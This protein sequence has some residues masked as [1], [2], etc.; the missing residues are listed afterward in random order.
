MLPAKSVNMLQRD[1]QELIPTLTHDQ[2][3][4][5]QMISN[6]FLNF[7]YKLLGHY[8]DHMVCKSNI[9]NCLSLFG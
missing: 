6:V 5:N 4:D 1:L 7:M 2:I 8:K 9:N 3:E